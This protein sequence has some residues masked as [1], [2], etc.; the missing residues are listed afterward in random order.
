VSYRPTIDALCKADQ[1]PA[2]VFEL[3]FAPPRRWRLDVAWEAEKVALEIQ[4]GIYV[5]GRHTRGAA[6]EREMEKLNALA[7]MG[8]RVCFTTPRRI[9]EHWPA[10]VLAVRGEQRQS[11]SSIEQIA[12]A[13]QAAR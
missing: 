8:W 7:A 13:E 11:K 5:A 4:G 3:R 2:P 12:T 1:L 6:L 10:V 9:A